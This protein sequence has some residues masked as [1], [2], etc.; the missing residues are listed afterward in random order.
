MIFLSVLFMFVIFLCIAAKEC[1][2]TFHLYPLIAVKNQLS[3]RLLLEP[4]LSH[5]EP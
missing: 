1:S 4:V 5:R 2:H 3:A